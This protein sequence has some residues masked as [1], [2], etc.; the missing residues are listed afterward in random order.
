MG[1]VL[2]EGGNLVKHVAFPQ[3]GLLSAV[4]MSDQNVDV[5]IG[6]TGFEGVDGVREALANTPSLPLVTVQVPG[7]GILLPAE[8]LREEWN[9]G[10]LHQL[11]TVYNDV[12]VTQIAQCVLCNRLHTSEE[13]L[14][15]WLLMVQDRVGGDSF[16]IANSFIAALLGVRLSSVPVALGVLQQ[17]GLI[18]RTIDGIVILDRKQLEASACQCYTVLRDRY[19]LWEKSLNLSA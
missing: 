17:A 2:I 3:S 14:S 9:R 15:R 1:T 16:D 18:R 8:T 11:L 7:Q 13:R 6:M 19:A 5:E 4:L 10:A 12:S